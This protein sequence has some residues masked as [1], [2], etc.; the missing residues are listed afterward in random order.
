[1]PPPPPLVFQQNIGIMYANMYHFIALQRFVESD[2]ALDY[3]KIFV[4]KLHLLT[5]QHCMKRE[6][7][8]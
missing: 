5:E 6:R 4:T 7:T 1:M 2:D 8:R 3:G